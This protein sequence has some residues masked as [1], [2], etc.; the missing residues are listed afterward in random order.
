MDV[1]IIDYQMSNLH[2]VQA[3]CERVGLSSTITADPYE[4]LA[5]KSAILPGVG[6]F[7]V[8]M[9]HLVSSGLEKCIV[10][11]LD[12]CY[13]PS[14]RIKLLLLHLE[15]HLLGTQEAPCNAVK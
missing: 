7:G 12:K 14:L 11:P 13:L 6:A 3:A 4:I 15:I 9:Q 5:A 8:A 2:S 1:A 10:T